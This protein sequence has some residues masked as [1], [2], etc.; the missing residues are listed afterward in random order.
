MKKHSIN[1]DEVRNLFPSLNRKI[2]G[3]PVIYFDGPAGTQVPNRVI[4][5]ISNYYRYYNSNSHGQFSAS[6]ATDRILEDA[7][8]NLAFFLGAESPQCISIGQ[9]MTSLNYMLSRAIEQVLHPGDEILITQLDHEANRTPWLELRKS[10]IKVREVNLLPKGVLDYEDM[11][12]KVNENTR[13]VAMGVASNALGTVNDIKLARQLTYEVGAWLLVDA[14]HYAP[15][16]SIDVQAMGVDF[17]LCSGYKFYG[18]HLGFL[19]SKDGLLN[20]LPTSRLRTQNQ[21]APYVIETGTL[22]HAAIAGMNAALAFIESLGNGD[23]IVERMKS[24]MSVINNHEQVMAR[25]LFSGISGIKDL[26]IVGPDFEQGERAPTI[27]F[28]HNKM[29]PTELCKALGERNISAWDGHFYAIRA[30]EVLGLMEKGGVT[31]IGLSMYNDK[32]D[33]DALLNALNDV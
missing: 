16:F 11:R 8:K 3:R 27:S 20:Q 14:V 21:S 2:K 33:I 24:G 30:M 5:A 28:V 13:L 19:Y 7:R 15:H 18:P 9:N 25:D 23:N 1:I 6:I 12:R 26:T 4:R 10:G 29:H 22:N 31:R 17:L 32:S